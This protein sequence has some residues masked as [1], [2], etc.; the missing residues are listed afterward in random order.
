M[1]RC[2]GA[3]QPVVLYEGKQFYFF[4]DAGVKII[5]PSDFHHPPFTWCFVDSADA[6][7]LPD[8]IYNPRFRLFP[9]YITSPKEERWGKL[10]QRRKPSLIIMNPWTRAELHKA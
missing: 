2:L 10:H 6:D 3:K 1:Y 7:P 4:S 9:I 8:V 5:D